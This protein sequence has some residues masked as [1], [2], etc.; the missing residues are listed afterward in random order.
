MRLTK[1]RFLAFCI[2][3][4]S[5]LSAKGLTQEVKNFNVYNMNSFT[6]FSLH[7]NSGCEKG[8]ESFCA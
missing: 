5:T 1:V 6:V 7:V 8:H 4:L 3:P 2:V